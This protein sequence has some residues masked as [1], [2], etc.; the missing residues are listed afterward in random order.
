MSSTDDQTLARDL[1]AEAGRRLLMTGRCPSRGRN[2][3]ER[4]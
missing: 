2:T 1:A 3:E 4:Q